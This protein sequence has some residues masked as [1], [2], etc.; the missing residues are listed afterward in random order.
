MNF[1]EKWKADDEKKEQEHRDREQ[2][3]HSLIYDIDDDGD[4]PSGGAARAREL[5][6]ILNISGAIA[7]RLR[8]AVLESRRLSQLAAMEQAR[9]A[10]RARADRDWLQHLDSLAAAKNRILNDRGLSFDESKK[11]LAHVQAEWDA[12]T[13]HHEASKRRAKQALIESQVA[14]KALVD[15]SERFPGLKLNTSPEQI[16][17]SPDE[18]TADADPAIEI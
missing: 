14:K 2:E 5:A 18:I 6:R 13:K 4:L 10:A 11:R 15:L 8:D 9:D 3:F 7:E 1:I 12:G 16:E 17:E